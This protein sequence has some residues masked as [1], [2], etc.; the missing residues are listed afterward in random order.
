MNITEDTTS[1][2]NSLRADSSSKKGAGTASSPVST[3]RPSKHGDE[4]VSA[5]GL[6]RPRTDSMLAGFSRRL[7]RAPSVLLALLAF[8]LTL[9]VRE[10]SAQWPPYP[11]AVT[12]PAT[13]VTTSSATLN[14][15]VYPNGD[16]GPAWFS[17]GTSTAYGNQTGWT[18][19]Q[20][21]TNPVPFSAGLVGLTPSTTY[22]FC[23]NAGALSGGDQSFTTLG[24][25]QVLTLPA[26]GTTNSAMINGMVNPNGYPTS[27]W[28]QWGTTTNYGNLTSVTNLGNGTTALPLSALLAGLTPNVNYH[29]RVAAT[30][31]YGQVYGNDQSFT[32]AGGSPLV[33]T[34]PPTGVSA[35][36]ATLNGTVNPNRWPTTAWFQW[37]ASTNYGNLS[38]MINLGNGTNPVPLSVRL[39]SLTTGTTYHY[40]VAA[41]NSPDAVCGSD[42]SFTPGPFP[43][44]DVEWVDVRG[45]AN[46]LVYSLAVS[47]TNLY[48]GGS[49][50][51]PASHIAKWDGINW[52]DLG[53]GLN[54]AP[55][56]LA[57]SGTNLY[58]GGYFTTAGEVRANSIAKWDGSTWS[59]LGSG[60]SST[61]LA[62][63]NALA[64]DGVNLYAG[65]QFDALGGVTA[66]NIAKWD[67]TAWSALGAGMNGY[68]SALAV[69][70]TN[71]YAGGNFTTAGGVPVNYIAKWDGRAW[72]ALGSGMSSWVA[73]LAMIGTN[74]Y[75]G[76]GFTMAGGIPVEGIAKWDGVAWSGLSPRMI[77]GAVMALAVS[78]TD[79]Y[80]GG[81]FTAAN[82]IA[83]WDGSDWSSLGQGVGATAYQPYVA[84]LAAD[85]LGRLFVGG[86]FT[87]AGGQ[88]ISYIA[89]ANVAIAPTVLTFP[90]TAIAPA[91]ATLNGTVNPNGHPTSAWFQWG[92]TTDYGQ[93]TAAT[94]MGS[95]I[96]ALPLSA[97][98]AGLTFGVTY[99]FRTAATNDYGLV[100]GSDQ[101]FNTALPGTHYVSLGSTNPTPPYTT[102]VT[103]ARNIQDAVDISAW[104]EEI[105]VTNGFYV[106]GG[107][108]VGT[109]LLSNRVAIDRPVTVRS[110]NG[111]GLTIIGGYQ[112][113]GTTNGDGAIRCAYLTDGAV[114]SGFTLTNGATRNAGDPFQERSG[115]GAGCA[116]TNAFL[117]NCVIV[118]NSASYEGGGAYQ[119]TLYNCTL[120][121]NSATNGGGALG[122]ALYNCTL[123][124]NSASGGIGGGACSCTLSNCTLSGNWAAYE[125][126]GAFGCTLYNCTLSGNSAFTIGGG[127]EQC[128][129]DNCALTGNWAYAGGGADYCTL[130]NCTLTGNSAVGAGPYAIG[131]GATDCKLYN[132]IVYFNTAPQEANYTATEPLNYCCTT[133]LPTNGVGNITLDPQ[134]ASASCL[135]ADSP[136]R[137]AGSAAYAS[138]TDID[139]E[140][141]GNPPSMG[142]DEYHAGAV[143]GP[144][145]V[146]LVVSST[147]VAVGSPVAL[148][149]LMEGRTTASVWEFGDG[150]AATNQP[151]VTHSWTK[152]GDYLVALWAF[153]ESHEGGVGATVTVHVLA[154]PVAYV[155]AT[156]THPQP[157][158]ASWATAATNIQAAVDEAT[159]A[160]ALVMVTNGVYRGGVAVTK[161]LALLSVNGP[162]FTIINGGGTNQC[163]SLTNGASLSGF[164]L[165]NGYTYG[166][167]GVWCASTNAFLTNCT[168]VGNSGGGAYQGTLYNCTLSGNSAYNG[169]G[170]NSCTLYNCTLSGNSASWAGG[171]VQ[172]ILYNCTLTNNMAGMDPKYS[173]GGGADGCTLY[174]C[175]LSGN[176]AAWGGGASR[177]TLYNCIVYFNT[178]WFDNGRQAA[179]YDSSSTLN[180]C[181]A[182]PLP[183]NGVSNIASDPLFVDYVHGNLRLQSNSPCINA[184]N[185]A[186]VTTTT[187][188]DGRPRIVGRTVDIGAYEDQGPF[189]QW[190]QQ[191]GL[192]TDG[193]ADYA[194]PDHDGMNNWQEW[195]CGTNPT[196]VLSVLR[197]VS[198]LPTSTN[199]TVTW[200]SVVGVNY[201]LERGENLASPFTLWATN[202]LG[203]AGTTRYADTHITGAG[204]FFYRVGVKSP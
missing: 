142:C 195:V 173:P 81:E 84:A 201:S 39:T 91:S 40:R 25:P 31:D 65:G 152:A 111:P 76:G 50:T 16:T 54:G 136:C 49:F 191:Y 83:K 174:N 41:T 56:A 199:T 159:V 99:H 131:G 194:D 121:G 155:S 78:G 27:A 30:N 177:S 183:P 47:G 106:T 109:S 100:Y 110:V 35:D 12:E 116:S 9:S 113:P 5:P 6:N 46:D 15:L 188:L 75:A 168:I 69:S 51:M 162:K 153:N 154:Q 124:G 70:G 68:V 107:R 122:C 108:P 44:S 165:T 164:T 2:T 169:G 178:D 4:A 120:S 163:V 128:T 196:N 10:A 45:G 115:G 61:T 170:A 180:Y 11:F 172:C 87:M 8:A 200:Q 123:T 21:G 33:W 192:P 14:G 202:I 23:A 95:G 42:Q 90:A 34:G 60:M 132:C 63:V 198:A 102:W 134:L 179:N 148:T 3:K 59:S 28:F 186:Y 43:F 160:G 19:I 80:V 104:G 158:Y 182:I 129:L 126:G 62:R 13:A 53:S 181:C 26:T 101:S 86:Y 143:T 190:L 149:G 156:S 204:P 138:G 140:P 150:N 89:Q 52:W 114:L 36:S 7:S 32:T 166:G 77:G 20:G 88:W 105:V 71:L 145:S 175:T 67:G 112:L 82:N 73:A 93:V 92:T 64:L 1:A 130:Y 147:N 48:A 37:G 184:G 133:P 146:S 197:M 127:S 203:Q 167:G 24:L 185:N 18:T 119:G 66:A 38:S 17:W 55:L 58:A 103:A 97:P 98:L 57:V 161:P 139:G 79:L 189:N 151:Y 22:H 94:A 96:S 137:G 135:S 157:P 141:W 171:A 193:S 117:T 72:S 144:L 29:F 85:G 118:G 176:S 74:L 187:D 125:G